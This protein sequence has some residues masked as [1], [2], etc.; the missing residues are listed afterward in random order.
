MY[1]YMSHWRQTADE[2]L[3]ATIPQGNQEPLMVKE[4][5]ED[6]RWVGWASPWNVILFSLQC[7]DTVGWAT[8]RHP[9]C[10]TLGVGLLMVTIW[11]ELI[12]PAVTT[13][14]ILSSNKIQNGDFLVLAYPDCLGK[15]PLNVCLSCMLVSFDVEWPHLLQ[16]YG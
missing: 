14:I 4:M 7:F 1:A 5:L 11:L 6:R 13:S 8:G 15:W 16:K 3:L 2:R 9:V 12:A 10:K